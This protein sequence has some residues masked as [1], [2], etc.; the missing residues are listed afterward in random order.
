MK[1][2]F[3]VFPA[4]VLGMAAMAFGQ[5]AP[6]KV[7]IIHVQNAILQTK[8]GQKAA[9]E[10]QGRF[11]PKKAGLDKKQNEIATL[12]DQLRKGSATMSEDAKA[13]LM[14][15]I[16]A[17]NKSLQ[18]D[19]E[20]AQA[21][22]DSEQGKIMQDLGGKVM[23]VLEK[24][25]TANGYAVVLDVSNPQTPVLWAA[26]AVDITG[27]IVKLYDQANSGADGSAGGVSATIARIEAGRHASMPAMQKGSGSGPITVQNDTSSTLTVYFSGPADRKE[28]VSAHGKVTV[29]LG[30][31]SY[32]VAGE[33]ADKSVLPFFGVRQY[34][35][36][37]TEQFFIDLA[38]RPA[39][40][41][42][43][44]KKK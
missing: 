12:Q 23:A 18:R 29:P 28:V 24:F 32:K 26:S 16:D 20:D 38:G 2:N 11:A 25:A 22:L 10:L 39:A 30:P 27:D 37:E 33:L 7:A 40:P 13:K 14:R 19:T 4:L 5:A 43:A 8:D 44:P 42:P 41:A 6:T 35:G 9:N 17:G 34:S 15:D 31:G 36:G 3:V 21:D 1:K